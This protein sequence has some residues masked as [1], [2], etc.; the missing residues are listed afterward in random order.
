MKEKLNLIK[1]I[2][3]SRNLSSTHG[4]FVELF[5]HEIAKYVDSK[6]AIA[7]NS[8]TSALHTALLALGVG[9]GDE[10]IVPAWT[11]I[12]S[13]SAIIM[14]GATPVFSDISRNSFNIDQYSIL[15]KLT[16]KTKAVIVVHLNG[17]PIDTG[18]IEWLL[19]DRN[20]ALIEDACQSLG[21]ECYDEKVGTI[22]NIGVYSFYPSKIITTGEGG[23]IVT[24]NN[25]LAKKCRS[26]RN[27]AR[28][29]H[30]YS[31]ELG[32]NYRMTEIQGAL[33]YVELKD[34][35]K[36]IID[37]RKKYYECKN[38]LESNNLRFPEIPKNVKIAPTYINAWNLDGKYK[39]KEIY[40]P[41]YKLPPFKQDIKLKWTEY[42]S[43]YGVFINL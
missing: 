31:T 43:K 20:I 33:G 23:M 39:D 40:T 29:K 14:C 13:V 30:F 38:K 32:F 16:D 24:N 25:D 35:D 1:Q 41:L 12:S 18:E 6:H 11:F 8:G 37:N 22:G 2:L 15:D 4:H 36:R 17:I 21:A 10:V 26:I 5:E 9:K 28:T 19:F 27:H 3:E 42:A 7:V 34:L